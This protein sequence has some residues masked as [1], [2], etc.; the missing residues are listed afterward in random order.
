MTT[1]I[2]HILDVDA[3]SVIVELGREL[4]DEEQRRLADVIGSELM[5][6]DSLL[7]A[8]PH[9]VHLDVTYHETADGLVADE[10]LYGPDESGEPVLLW[11]AGTLTE[12]GGKSLVPEAM[13]CPDCGRGTQGGNSDSVAFDFLSCSSIPRGPLAP[14][15]RPCHEG[16]L[17][18]CGRNA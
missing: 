18:A 15:Q 16:C 11:T 6:L 12:R 5:R 14:D 4:S 9:P 10:D 1:P 2:S 3:G 7:D 17:V 13:A 8:K